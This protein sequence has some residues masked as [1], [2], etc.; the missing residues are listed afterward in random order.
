[1]KRIYFYFTNIFWLAATGCLSPLFYSLIKLR[2]R[3]SAQLRILVIPPVKIGDLVCATPVFRAIKIGWPECRLEAVLLA[4]AGRRDSS[5]QLLKNN[6][7]LDEIIL[8]DAKNG[9]TIVGIIKLIRE[10]Y[11]RQYDWSFVLT[12]GAVE[13]IIC[14]WSAISN[15]AAII[16]PYAPL[17]SR[18]LNFS[19]SHK[20]AIELHQL[21]LRRYLALLGFIGLTN[22]AEKKEIFTNLAEEAKADEFLRENHLD[23]KD[24]LIGI[25]VT[26]GNKIKEWPKEKFARLAERLISELIIFIISSLGQVNS[27]LMSK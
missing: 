23:Q 9:L 19:V 14:F 20:L 6:P 25:A 27:I 24:L 8:P 16:S 10:I 3:K 18:L 22:C 1:M 17:T 13:K 4:G 26:A 5:Y 2:K 21:A 12:P 11:R 15:R 7:S